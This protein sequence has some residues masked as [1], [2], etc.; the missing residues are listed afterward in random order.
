M[1]SLVDAPLGVI[2]TTNG[3]LFGFL[4]SYRGR[5]YNSIATLFTSAPSGGRRCRTVSARA[6]NIAR[7]YEGAKGVQACV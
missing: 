1:S 7:A 5:T 2:R 3:Y 4:D 6:S